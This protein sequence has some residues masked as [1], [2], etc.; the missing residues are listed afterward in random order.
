MSRLIKIMNNEIQKYKG[1]IYAVVNGK[2]VKMPFID[3]TKDYDHMMFEMHHYVPFTDWELNTKNVISKVDQ[4]L[5]LIPK[6]MHQHL[7]NPIYRLSPEKFEQVYGIKPQLL[8][9]DVNRRGFNEIPAKKE[10]ELDEEFHCFDD[11][12]F[13]TEVQKYKESEVA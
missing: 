12:D 8:L 10:T 13:Q 2:L 3:S 9:F 7:E 11:V 1:N 5:I 4:K 6:V